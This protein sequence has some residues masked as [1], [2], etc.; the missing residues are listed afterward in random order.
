MTL[1]FDIKNAIVILAFSAWSLMLIELSS[2]M[3]IN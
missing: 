2:L 3:G 1:E